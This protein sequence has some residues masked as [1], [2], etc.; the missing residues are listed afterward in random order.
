MTKG[1]FIAGVGAFLPDNIVTNDDL[2]QKVDT[3]DAWIVERTGIHS[4]H[5]AAKG[6]LTSDL[7]TRAAQHAL[8]NAGMQ[9]DELDMII[10]A[11][12]TPDKTFPATATRIQQ[13]LGMKKGFAFD[14]QAACSG[15]LYALTVADS[16]IRMGRV[17]TALVIGAETL[18]RIVDWTDRNTCVLFGDGAGAIILKASDTKMGV[19]DTHIYSD[20][21]FA[22]LLQ[23]TGGASSSEAVGKIKMKGRDVFRH[24]VEKLDEA[25]TTLLSDH[26]LTATD[27]QWFIPHQANSRIIEATAKKLGFDMDK[28]VVTVGTHANTSAASIPL[29]LSCAIETGKVKRG[30]V[31]LMDAF[32]GGFTWAAALIRY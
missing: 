20:G 7:A 1:S 24:A 26:H 16:F 14:I 5:I 17:K 29:A 27:I 10:V 32:G 13:N 4:R 30:D 25:A 22:D 23:A 2:A 15:F 12:T 28:V 21:S 11:T 3:S 6:E 19:I 9:A 8:Q 18:S 31:I